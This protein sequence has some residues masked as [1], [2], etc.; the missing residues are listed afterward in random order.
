MIERKLTEQD[1]QTALCEHIERKATEARLKHGLYIDA[2]Q[3]MRI[4]DDRTVVRYPVGVRFDSEPLQPGEF[5]WPMPLGD[6]PSKGYCLF[7]HP[8]FE[9]Q[10]DAW[11]ILIAYHIPSIN[12]GEIASHVESELFGA[13]LLGLDTETYYQALCELTDSIP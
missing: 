4:L 13:T 2:E 8:W 3:I 7:I 6:D 1:G 10:S 9:A 12:Y 11:P 5:A